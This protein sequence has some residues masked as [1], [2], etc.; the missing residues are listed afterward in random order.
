[1]PAI[2]TFLTSVLTKLWKPFFAVIG[3][4]FVWLL[5]Y[6]KT[7]FLGKIAN[8]ALWNMIF[9]SPVYTTALTLFL[10][11]ITLAW[12]KLFSIIVS[13]LLQVK[14]ILDRVLPKGGGGAVSVGEELSSSNIM[15]VAI[16]SISAIGIFD[17]FRD[18]W[19]LW[20]PFLLSLISVI[21][22]IIYFKAIM[23]VLKR[24]AEMASSGAGDQKTISSKRSK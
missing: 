18:T 4:F 3:G 1:M 22:A 21:G 10:T 14:D 12:I 23:F 20:S 2:I 8:L 5:D 13:A 19:S 16:D 11:V 6:L 9:S 15:S 17:V 24:L 7:R